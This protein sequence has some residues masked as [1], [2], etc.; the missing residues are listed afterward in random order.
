[1]AKLQRFLQTAK[2]DYAKKKKK[3]KR[4]SLSLPRNWALATCGKLLIVVPNKAQSAIPPL[5]DDT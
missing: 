3:K 1:M 5:S 4:K 2:P